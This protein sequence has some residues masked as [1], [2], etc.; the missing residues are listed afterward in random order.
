MRYVNLN[1]QQILHNYISEHQSVLAFAMD[2]SFHSYYKNLIM[3]F[4]SVDLS[5][6]C[7]DVQC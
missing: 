2:F 6:F 4:Y 3:K 1:W 7:S 5:S